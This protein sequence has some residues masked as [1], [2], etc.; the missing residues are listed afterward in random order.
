MYNYFGDNFMRWT[1]TLLIGFVISSCNSSSFNE[2]ELI[3]TSSRVGKYKETDST[4]LRIFIHAY[5]QIDKNGYCSIVRKTDKNETKFNFFKIDEKILRTI[6]NRLT[7]INSDTTLTADLGDLLYDGPTIELLVHKADGS[8]I[9][10]NF[11]VV[12]EKTDKDFLKLYE[13]VDSISQN[14]TNGIDI[15]TT[16]LLRDRNVQINKLKNDAIELKK[17]FNWDTLVIIK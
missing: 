10:L 5:A 11:V 14:S 9:K 3:S 2:L 13:Y 16:K 8:S 15:D 4:L 17:T 1:I 6:N 12:S 7:H